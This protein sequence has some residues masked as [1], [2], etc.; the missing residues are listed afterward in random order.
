MMSFEFW[1]LSDL[2]M[3]PRI[4]QTLGQLRSHLVSRWARIYLFELWRKKSVSSGP[5]ALCALSYGRRLAAAS[6]RLVLLLMVHALGESHHRTAG[7]AQREI[8]YFYK[9]ILL[10]D[11][12]SKNLLFWIPRNGWLHFKPSNTRGSQVKQQTLSTWTLRRRSF[13]NSTLGASLR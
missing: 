1:V 8:S 5:G 3:W 9:S 13:K 12:R 6:L 10:Y 2:T 11:C 7:L 4:V